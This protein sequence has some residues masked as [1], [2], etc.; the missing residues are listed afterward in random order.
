VPVTI[1]PALA[2]LCLEYLTCSGGLRPPATILQPFGRPRN[3]FVI[4]P[5]TVWLQGPGS[6]LVLT[7]RSM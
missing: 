5:L 3:Q 1:G 2:V 4:V 6:P 7:Q